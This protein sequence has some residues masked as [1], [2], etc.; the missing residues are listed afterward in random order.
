MHAQHAGAN[1]DAAHGAEV[2]ARHDTLAPS[3][4]TTRH[5]FRLFADGGAIELRASS[6]A[7]TATI[8]AVRKHLKTIE[9]Q[10]ASGD[11]TTPGFVHGHQPDG[12]AEM[13]R[14]GKSIDYRYE[15]LSDGGR[16]RIRTKEADGLAA[17]HAFMRFQIVEHR[18]GD[19]GEIEAR[20]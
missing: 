2:D 11:F 4:E 20:P 10:F 8:N 17:V 16:I 7:D 13:A 1:G 6:P 15:K 18:T 14:L 19:V 9:A 5:S 12:V 3:H